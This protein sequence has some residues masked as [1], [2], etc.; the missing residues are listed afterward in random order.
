MTTPPRARFDTAPLVRLLV[1]AV[2]G[3]VGGLVFA[4]RSGVVALLVGWAVAALVF[5]GW[6][7]LALW[8]MNARATAAHATREEPTRA[9]AHVLVLLA[10]VV[11]VGAVIGVLVGP[12]G[13]SAGPV[14]A[15]LVAIVASWAALHTV[16]ALRYARM[17]FSGPGGGIDFHQRE[18]PRYSDFAYVA[19]TVGMSFAISDTDLAS[20]AMRRTA[21]VHALLAYLF[22]TVI[23]A[24]AVNVVAGL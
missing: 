20:S 22:G 4:F 11:S 9:G 10:A 17:Y 16:F 3:V 14:A 12:S 6:T 13:S 1:G 23:I 24:S 21:L 15:T 8:P 18:D 2:L 7:W 5:V 19:F